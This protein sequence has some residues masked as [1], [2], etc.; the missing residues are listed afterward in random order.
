M[1]VTMS[2]ILH[3]YANDYI[4]VGRAQIFTNYDENSHELRLTQTVK[5]FIA[6]ALKTSQTVALNYKIK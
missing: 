2:I 3:E 5:I 1:L 4:L 6:K